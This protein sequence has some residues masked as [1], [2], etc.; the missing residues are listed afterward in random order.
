MKK[1][2][3]IEAMRNIR[4][5]RVSFLSIVIISMLAVVAYLGLSFSAE[6]FK[7]SV[8]ATYRAERFADIEISAF[9]PFAPKDLEAVAGAEGILD[10][11]GAVQI[12]SRVINGKDT[13]DIVLR[14]V[15]ERIGLPHLL[16]GRMPEKDGECAVEKKLAKELGCETGDTVS[17][18]G[19]SIMTD[20]L[21]RGKTYTITGVFVYAEHPTEMISYEPLMLVTR[22]AFN[23][24]LLPQGKYT[25][26]LVRMESKEAYRFSD[27]WINAADHAKQQL[28]KLNSQW[29]VTAL[30]STAG[31]VSTRENAGLLTTVSVTFSMLF[32]LIAA[33]VI[34]STISRLVTNESRLVG[35]AKAMGLKN[36]EIFAK[37]LLFGMGGA[38]LGAAIGI[39]MAYFAFE[40]VVLYFFGVVFTLGEWTYAFLAVPSLI[41]MA[42]AAALGF[43]AVFLACS[44]LL[45]STA[46]SLMSGQ[47]AVRRARKGASSS[48]GALYIKLMLR[49]M[50]TDWRRVC[51]SVVS[52]AGCCMLLF[53]GFSLKYA[54]S[55]VPEKQYGEIQRFDMEI[56]LS[57]SAEREDVDGI[58]A[59]LNEENVENLLVFTDAVLYRS[60]DEPGLLTLICPDDAQDFRDFYHL[61]DIRDGSLLS[62]PS[63]GALVS[64]TFAAKYHLSAGD[65][66]QVLDP[67]M[68]SHDMEVAGMFENYIGINVV[69]SRP[70]A[71][72]CLGESAAGNALLLRLS[73]RDAAGLQQRL[74]GMPGF[75]ALSSAQKQQALFDGMSAMLN[76]VILLLGAL[77]VMIACFIL[78]NLVS[79]YVNQKK[80]ELT[81]MR[82]NGYTTGETIRYASMECYGI[83]A[84]GILLGLAAGHAF[85]VF[86]IH[87]IE[88]LSMGFVKEPMWISF[89]A[90]ALITA[91]IS[92]AVHFFAFRKIRG[93]KLSDMQR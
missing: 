49:N 23:S 71:E 60:G 12:P 48:Q 15:T 26:L 68:Q 61:R 20:A 3:T 40:R 8:D 27:A 34:Y 1:T 6:G 80:N 54:I 81:I 86:L 63:S 22:G 53:I 39:L 75:V 10:A 2:Q 82:I 44:R 92:A 33:L 5:N 67:G 90:S 57:P 87:L 74:S 45:R 29:I 65:H 78:L 21:I 37:Y 18:T 59:V 85:S 4:R 46:V 9:A 88:Q 76:L 36:S 13:R 52:I 77:A 51:V 62:V 70:Y 35:A 72:A 79:T 83:T 93:L 66:F 55:R 42:G 32:V 7:K 69:C 56:A 84:L 28:E 19:R 16:E 31:Y 17:L 25:R 11:E 43:A 50:R 24:M 14:T 91:V 64:R 89:A 30:H 58:R 73:G 41:V 47:N 38:M